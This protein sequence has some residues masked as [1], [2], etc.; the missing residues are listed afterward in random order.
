MTTK[1]LV[2]WTVGAAVA[3][4]AFALVAATVGGANGWMRHTSAGAGAGTHGWMGMGMG[5]GSWMGMGTG[6]G[7]GMLLVGLLWVALLVGLLAVSAYWLLARDGNGERARPDPAMD[8]LRTRYAR[9]EIDEAEF[10]SRRRRLTG[11]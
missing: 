7:V 8:E 4:A 11:Q 3:T 2:G 5:S 1:R 10:E 6:W 9:G